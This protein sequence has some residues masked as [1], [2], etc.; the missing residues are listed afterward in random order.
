MWNFCLQHVIHIINKLPTPLLNSKSTYEP[1]FKTPPS[2][3]HLKVYGCLCYATFMHAH[4]TKFDSRARKSIF[5]GYQ[6]GTKGFLLYDLSGHAI[7]LSRNVIFYESCFSFR[8]PAN[9]SSS[10]PIPSTL[11]NHTPTL[12]DIPPNTDPIVPPVMTCP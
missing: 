1:L 10:Q 5:T 6:E 7:F 12:D 2:Y 8:I 9:F 3:M 4:M 11:S